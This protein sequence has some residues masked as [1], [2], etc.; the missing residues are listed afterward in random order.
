MKTDK[1]AWRFLISRDDPTLTKTVSNTSILKTELGRDKVLI[2]VERFSLTANNILYVV[3]GEQNNYWDL[4]PAEDRWGNSPAWGIGRVIKS[5]NNCLRKGERIFGFFPLASYCILQ[6]VPVGTGHVMDDAPNRSSL[7]PA[8]N[9]YTRID[10]AKNFS[11]RGG[12]WQMLLRPLALVGLLAAQFFKD[13]EYFG[14]RIVYVTSASSKTGIGVGRLIK[15]SS[16]NIKV[17][18]VTSRPKKGLVASLEIFDEVIDYQSI[19]DIKLAP[20]ILF[21]LTGNHEI[22]Q[23]IHDKLGSLL[24]HSAAAGRSHWSAKS[25]RSITGEVSPERFFTPLVMQHYLP[26]WGAKVFEQRFDAAVRS[27]KEALGEQIV[28]KEV[29]GSAGLADLYRKLLDGTNREKEGSVVVV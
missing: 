11:G 27:L 4:F 2:A 29:H 19:A 25:D 24:K 21:D 8:Y 10:G 22:V 18:G 13:R 5:D 20:S 9:R 16:P 28:L 26:V 7:A 17:I 1:N 14:A 15:G 23:E 6:P 12:D 3:L